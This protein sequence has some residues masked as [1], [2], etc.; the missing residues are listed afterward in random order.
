MMS[1]GA[2]DKK[3]N[4]AKLEKYV[5]EKVHMR[6]EQVY[7]VVQPVEDCRMHR[8]RVM[9]LVPKLVVPDRSRVAG[10]P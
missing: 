6:R 10:S 3:W 5:K 9:S 7:K 2:K 4:L 1:Q 8:E